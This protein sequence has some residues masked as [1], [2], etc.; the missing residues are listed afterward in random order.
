MSNPEQETTAR[1]A[2]GPRWVALAGIAG[3]LIGSLGGIAG[4]ILVYQQNEDT[5]KRAREERRADIR[6]KSYV[7]LVSEYQTW[8]SKALGV[9]NMLDAWILEKDEKAS[10]KTHQAALDEYNASFVPAHSRSWQTETAVLL[11]GTP[12]AGDIA[13]KLSAARDKAA[14]QLSNGFQG[15]EPYNGEKFVEAVQ[16]CESLVNTFISKVKKEVVV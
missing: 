10:A 6:R 4:S 15:D 9:S 11:V 3:T 5:Q 1:A 7:D 12:S 8:Q 16:E 2:S 14:L 13:R